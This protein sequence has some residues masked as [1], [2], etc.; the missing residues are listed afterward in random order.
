MQ[1][2]LAEGKTLAAIRRELQLDHSTV[3]RFARAKSLNELL[4]KATNRATIL[5][6][7]KPY[8]HRRWA[9]GCRDIPHLHHELRE[10]GYGGGIQS[11]RR[12]FQSAKKPRHRNRT[13]HPTPSSVPEPRSVPKPRRI[14]GWIMRPPDQLTDEHQANLKEIRTHCPH[15]DAATRHVRDFATML[16]DLTG[17]NLPDWMNRV[18]DDDLPAFHTLVTGLRRDLDAVVAGLSTSWSSG[19]VEGHVTRRQA[20]Q[21]HGLRPSQPRPPTPTSTPHSLTARHRTEASPCSTR[22]LSECPALVP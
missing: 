12:Y 5:D 16:R 8:L 4:V 11:V 9:E 17:T 19:Q 22:P 15:L 6:K 3:R 13:N 14:V 2:R 21:T 20:P 7:Y 1:Q 18:L 10:M